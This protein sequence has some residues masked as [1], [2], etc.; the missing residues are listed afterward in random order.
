MNN[1]QLANDWIPVTFGVGGAVGL[2]GNI[3]LLTLV[4]KSN[5]YL[6]LSVSFQ[7]R[8]DTNNGSTHAAS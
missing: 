6:D 3:F 8:K 1:S 4:S 7:Y 2:I 5:I